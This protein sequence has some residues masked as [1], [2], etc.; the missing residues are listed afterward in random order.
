[1]KLTRYAMAAATIAAGLAAASSPTACFAQGCV[2]AHSSQPVVAGLNGSEQPRS[3]CFLHGLTLTTSFRT[4]SSYKHYIGTVYQ[5]QREIA[6]N[7]VQNHADLYDL[8]VN[9]QL[10][11]R[12]SLIADVPAM[13]AT[14]HQQGS[15]PK[16]IFRSGGIGDVTVGAQA[17]IFRPP[18]ESHGNI[19][20]SAA[21]KL[22]TGINDAK[23]R[24]L[25]SNGQL[26]TQPFDESI[27]P[28]DGTWGFQLST[29]AYHPLYFH[30]YGY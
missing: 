9:Y 13:T 26:Q 18:T 8:S 16:N 28:G 20:I 3:S 17:W 25:L 12:W 15:D 19:A 27:Q 14:R 7:E 29:V 5:V 23:G 21:L 22:P 24:K 10:T 2:A 6:H 11:P 30:T 4:Y 1:M